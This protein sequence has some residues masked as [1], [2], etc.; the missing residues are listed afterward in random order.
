MGT[1]LGEF[2]AQ[3]MSHSNTII[4]ISF[5]FHLGAVL[6]E[7]LFLLGLC[8]DVGLISHTKFNALSGLLGKGWMMLFR[9]LSGELAISTC[10]QF[11]THSYFTLGSEQDLGPIL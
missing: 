1:S 9:K 3:S 11:G 4:A 10:C 5:Q 7:C 6:N 2:G 8:V